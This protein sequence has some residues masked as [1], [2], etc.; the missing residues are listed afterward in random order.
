MKKITIAERF[1]PFSHEIGRKFLL[2]HTSFSVQ[3]FPNCLYFVDLEEKRKSFSHHFD[4]V[5]PLLDFTAELDLERKFLR[6]FGTTKKGYM[7]Y[8]IAAKPDGIWLAMEKAP[9]EKPHTQLLLP[10]HT[11][12]L[13]KTEERLSLGVQKA[14][15][16]EAV[17]R[18]LD[19]KE[20][21]PLWLSLSHCIPSREVDT[22]EGNYTLIEE[23][24]RK[25]AG[26][27]KEKIVE[28]FQHLFLGAIDGIFVPRLYD[29]DHQG[30]LPETEHQKLLSPLPI[31]AQGAHLI[32][33]LFIQEK[34]G[35]IA[36]LPCLPPQFPCGRM[37]HVQ[38]QKGVTLHVEWTKKSLRRMQISS[39]H[40]KEVLLQLPKAIR[41]CRMRR[42][43]HL[44][45][46][47][48][49]LVVSLAP[50]ETLE[51]DRFES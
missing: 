40:E 42:R 24:R 9:K 5:G 47:H 1:H 22:Q 35:V 15:D 28:S 38:A 26:G 30:I 37:T 27:D 23:C 2:P 48:G 14:Q 33:S 12:I 8:S 11:E 17:R 34:E 49:R 10:C 43:R 31:L 16:W 3:V 45:D 21:F 36:L 44:L 7:R 4:F 32:R 50:R 20:I 13:P 25:I 46:R 29:T 18:R 41:S 39:L 6:V 19:C 51:L